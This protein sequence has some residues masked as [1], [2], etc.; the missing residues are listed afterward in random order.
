MSPATGAIVGSS[1][2]SLYD[3]VVRQDREDIFDS[4]LCADRFASRHHDQR[5]DYTNW[6]F[7][8]RRRLESRGWV[9][10]SP[11]L[12]TPQVV[13]GPSELDSVTFDI[14]A[15]AGAQVLADLV[16]ASWRSMRV[17][18]FA[19]YYFDNGQRDGE[20]GRLQMAPCMNDADGTLLMLICGIRLT[21]SAGMRDFEFWSETRREML[22]RITGGVYRLDRTTYARYRDEIR[23]QLSGDAGRAIEEFQL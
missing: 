19:D 7:R 5:R 10:K 2:V 13:F 22:L 14:V 20:L 18:R 8:Y 1:L 9:L 12:H 15:S 16:Q 3:G 21:G 11:I 4:L 17:H 6:F 23:N